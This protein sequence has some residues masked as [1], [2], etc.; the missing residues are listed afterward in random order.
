MRSG[1]VMSYI[2]GQGI[3]IKLSGLPS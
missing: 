2:N 3:T 1:S